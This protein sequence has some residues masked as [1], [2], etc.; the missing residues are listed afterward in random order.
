MAKMNLASM[1]VDALLTLRDDIGKMLSRRAEDLKRQL[2]RLASSATSRGPAPGRRGPQ[3]G[4]KV[5]P[6][7]RGPKGETWSGRGLR[8]RWL[9][10]ALKAGHK[11][12]DFLI[13]RR[14]G[15][16]AK[17]KGKAG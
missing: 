2:S 7:Y 4:R 6:K 5:P 16:K 14:A 8:P 1:S 10:A 9:S 11:V 13:A 12:D 15:S 3:K 17:R